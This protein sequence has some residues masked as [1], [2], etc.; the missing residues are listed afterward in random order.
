M[1]NATL[2]TKTFDIADEPITES[3]N[4][5]IDAK[6]KTQINKN[7]KNR[8]DGIRAMYAIYRMSHIIKVNAEIK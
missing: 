7:F 8:K 4:F 6:V 3:T 2:F 5:Y 1:Q